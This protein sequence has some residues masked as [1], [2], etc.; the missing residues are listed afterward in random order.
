MAFATV[1]IVPL[2]YYVLIVT[3]LPRTWTSKAQYL[4]GGAIYVIVGPFLN[5][6]VYCYASYYMDS[7]A[8][9]KTRK[10]V[11][12]D[13]VTAPI[14]V[15]DAEK[16]TA[17]TSI[18]EDVEA[19]AGLR[20][21]IQRT[22]FPLDLVGITGEPPDI[23]PLLNELSRKYRTIFYSRSEVL[24]KRIRK[25]YPPNHSTHFVET[26]HNLSTFLKAN[27]IFVATNSS[28]P[29]DMAWIN[30][31]ENISAGAKPGDLIVIHGRL[32]GP[33]DRELAV[34]MRQKFVL[35]AWCAEEQASPEG[36]ATER[37]MRVVGVD[38]ESF[39][40]AK[41]AFERVWPEVVRGELPPLLYPSPAGGE[42][43]A[44][45]IRG[46]ESDD[47]NSETRRDVAGGLSVVLPRYEN[48]AGK[49]KPAKV[50]RPP[51]VLQKK[52]AL[53]DVEK[54]MIVP[55]VRVSS[56]VV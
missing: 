6:A 28:P 7:F 19:T 49:V 52:F 36:S 27:I 5:I 32:P 46:S 38:E 23:D 37:V 50:K 33:E 4:V 20:Q 39:L 42:L 22:S 15:A 51:R 43:G 54:G 48:G 9:G 10:V 35:V 18:R 12:E 45:G 53:R 31:L 11:A 1:M 21:L 29:H 47:V 24:L 14:E 44:H 30:N 17:P 41:Q 26:T 40:R 3:W 13:P 2:M 16:A 8:W 55:R 56:V 25:K 34:R